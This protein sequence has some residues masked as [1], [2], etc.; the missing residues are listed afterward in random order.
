MSSL[1]EKNNYQLPNPLRFIQK[2][3]D[4]LEIKS[5]QV[6]RQ[7]VRLIPAQCPFAREVRLFGRVMFRIPPLCKLNP[8]YEQL[9]TL[10]FRALCFLAEQC[11]EDITIYCT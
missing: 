7:I 6:A 1:T 8:L 11:G 9:M 4:N 5:E 3:F 10:R 2:Q